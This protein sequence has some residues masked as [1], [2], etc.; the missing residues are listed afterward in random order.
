MR[1]FPPL[2]ARLAAPVLL[3]SALLLPGVAGAQTPPAPTPT[4]APPSPTPTPTP[5]PTPTPTPQGPT[6][7]QATPGRQTPGP[8][9]A[10]GVAAKPKPYAEVITKNAK[11]SAGLFKTHI[12][13]DK[14]YFEIPT[15]ALNK[16]LLWVTSLERSQTFYGF[17]NTELKERVIRFERR[18]D[19]VL[20][21]DVSYDYRADDKAGD[22]AR[23]LAKGNI[24]AI[25]GVYN[26]AAYG[27]KESSMV[28][29]ASSIIYSDLF[30]PRYDQTRSFVE[31]MKAFP[32][33][34]L[35][36]LTAT[37]AAGGSGGAS[38]FPPGPPVPSSGG[39]ANTVV[40]NHNIVLLP[41]KPMMPRLHDGRVGFFGT[42]YNE[43]GGPEN[44][45]KEVTYI[46]RWRL[47]KKDPSAALSEPV[48][49]ITYYLGD[50]IP[51]K[52]K[53]WVKK[54]VEAW[55]VAFEKA[56]FLNALVCRDLP[57][58]A[59]D[60]DF[61]AEDIRYTVVRWL[62]SGVENAYG[63]HI[64]DPRTGEILNGSPKIFHNILSLTQNWYFVQASACDRRAQKLPLP[65]DL[66]GELL[67]YVVTHEIGHTLGFPHN[68]K[69]SSSIPIKSLRDPQWTAQWGTEASIMDY[70][71]NNYVAQPGDGV[72]Q[73]KPKI[74]PYDLF[75][76]EWGYKPVPGAKTPDQ[77]KDVLNALALRQN[78]DPMLRFGNA[79]S[80]DPARQTEDLSA[81]SVEAT[82]L[83]LLN[84]DRVL[85]YLVSAT[86]KPGEDYTRLSEMY[87]EVLG[88]RA[89]EL[90]H[91]VAVVGGINETE[92]HAGQSS[93]LNYEPVSKAR[94]KQAVGLFNEKVFKTQP[95]LIRPDILSRIQSSGVAGRILSEQ[96]GVLNGLLS[97]AR[98]ARMIEMEA[99]RPAGTAYG[100]AEMMDDLRG[101]VFAELKQPRVTTDL[102]RRNLQRAFVTALAGKVNPPAPTPLTL[103]AGLPPQFVAQLA[104]NATVP[105]EARAVARGVL[106]DLKTTVAAAQPKAASRLDRLHL[107]DLSRQIDDALNPKK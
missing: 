84:L 74:G 18:A 35:V 54:G 90:N 30:G 47:E 77:E 63:P 7:G 2:P 42:T 70:G 89:R 67:A 12:V 16:E 25:L 85:G 78:A 104:A 62:P 94:Q 103:P 73:L 46:D 53:P 28:I 69:A 34:V 75:A 57:T 66:T 32:Q 8:G 97:N 86:T 58:K 81:D 4:P 31:S 100:I 98:L 1:S 21:R 40:I 27:P 23:A 13:D 26:V 3:L 72:T 101:G 39:T 106:L 79:S 24:E 14:Y 52:W 76:V 22:V 61:D 64:S 41:E 33:N 59:E 60:P 96:S 102:Y 9:A 49:P 87:G 92:Y 107:L 11:T 19:R 95:T 83:G 5:A 17:G 36:K 50:E 82:R 93:K 48:K 68:M 99:T 20:L 91:V 65:D 71:R 37:S 55:N 6:P 44:R 15:S 88:Q 105:G 29:D 10:P 43:L 38:P 45:V 51:A 56:G 80:E